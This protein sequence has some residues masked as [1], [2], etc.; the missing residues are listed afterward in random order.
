MEKNG[1]KVIGTK[2]TLVCKTGTG[3]HNGIGIGLLNGT[4]K[5]LVTGIGT[6]LTM[7]IM[8]GNGVKMDMMETCTNGL[9][10][11]ITETIWTGIGNRLIMVI[12][13]TNMNKLLSNNKEIIGNLGENNLGMLIGLMQEIIKLKEIG[14]TMDGKKFTLMDIMIILMDI[15]PTLTHLVMMLLGIKDQETLGI[16]DQETLG[17][18]DPMLLGIKDLVLVMLLGTLELLLL[19]IKDLVLEWVLD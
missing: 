9:D 7:E 11:T 5:L 15:I 13:I 4:G 14:I 3:L 16:K 10:I 2:V 12:I 8:T 1:T 6:I 18:K 17:I 19:G